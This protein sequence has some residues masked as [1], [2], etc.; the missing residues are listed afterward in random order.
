MAT[1]D[2]LQGGD[3]TNVTTSYP[4]YESDTQTF[5]DFLK[6]HTILRVVKDDEMDD[7]DSDNDEEGGAGNNRPRRLYEP[8][9]EEGLNVERV[10]CYPP[11]LQKIKNRA[12]DDDH[13][14]T[15]LLEIPLRELVAWDS[16]RGAD[17][18]DRA[19]ANTMRYQTL[20]G[21]VIDRYLDSLS[22]TE[23]RNQNGFLRDTEDVLHEQRMEQQAR[24]ND[25]LQQQQNPNE[26][27]DLQVGG[28]AAEQAE[29]TNN[30][31]QDQATT[32]FPPI[33]LRKYELRILPLERK[34]KL[35]PFVRQYI[36]KS[37]SHA[38]QIANQSGVSLRHVRAKS[39]GRLVTI[40]GMVV[41]ATDVKP[42]CQVATYSCDDCGAELYQVLNGQREFMPQRHCPNCA[43][44]NRRKSKFNTLHLQTRGSKFTKFQELKLQELPS[45][46]PMGHVPRSLSVYCRGE[47]TRLANPG[48]VITVDGVFLPQKVTEGG[49][50]SSRN[51]GLMATLFLEAQHL[52]LHKKSFDESLLDHLSEAESEQIDRD[53]QMVATS[54]DPIGI[55][56]ASIAPEIFGHENIKRALLLQL[57]GGVTRKLED[58]MKIRGDIN[59]CLMGDPGVAKSQLLKHV[60]SIAPRGVYTTGK[61]SSG[62][63]LTAAVT[64]NTVTGEL[65]LEGGALV[66]A[67]QGICAIDEFD[68]MDETDRTAIHEVMEQ[69]TVSIAKAGIVATLNART[70]VLAAANP[71]YSRYNRSKSLSEN[72]NLPNSLLSRFD[73]MF[74]ILDTPD[75]DKDMALARHVTFVHQNEGL[76]EKKDDD[77]DD[78]DNSGDESMAE[79]ITS[80]YD[81]TKGTVSPRLLRE[82]VAR[83]RRHE[84]TVP[85]EVAPYVVE[86]YVSLRMQDRPRR[87]GARQSQSFGTNANGGKS[88][89]Q[90]AM[91]ARQL[92]SILRLSQSLAR[93]R[94]SDFVAR[95]DVDEAIRLTHM[96]KASLEDE[97]TSMDGSKGKKREDIMSRVFHIIRDYATT[98]NCTFVELKLAEAMV[99][100]KGFTVQHL[101]SCLEEYEALEI[102]QVNSARTQ[103]HFVSN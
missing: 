3:I 25:F 93:L 41:R 13:Q 84:P 101:Q 33:L 50:R 97:G 99:L 19:I 2:T 65:S 69:Q 70:A 30:N 88:G 78:E 95:E 32:M 94:F 8:V 11:L 92:L 18:A 52:E 26:N 10:P 77:D 62:V 55:L 61:G 46:V 59:I 39:L 44:Q 76:E 67:D 21:Q 34:G 53:I 100:R 87:G 81:E 103:I 51:A 91:T 85:R 90:T 15:F 83:A 63:G 64:K 37:N 47:L 102:I 43:Q 17:L 68:K 80:D 74:L 12:Y 16:V 58:G 82:H 22:Q 96:S 27:I 79:A 73:L 60:S 45:Q 6:E 89:D 75:V 14:A 5:S 49:Y 72:I 31:N 38:T 86:A 98:S 9:A 57:T 54:E 1:Q 20:F 29:G 24:Q 7:S 42:Y 48:D 66:L 40:T 28:V 35:F 4:D 23:A 36:A 56:A 71:L